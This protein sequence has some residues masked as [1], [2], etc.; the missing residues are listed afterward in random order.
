MLTIPSRLIVLLTLLCAWA[1]LVVPSQAQEPY[2]EIDRLNPG[3]GAPPDD[4]VRNTPQ[5]TMEALLDSIASGD[6]DAASHLLNLS[7]LPIADQARQGP[8]LAQ[9]LH[10]IIDRKVV[11]DWHFLLQRPDALDSRA[12]S[13]NAVG[14]QVRRSLIIWILELEDRDV[15]IRLDRLKP[16]G[17]DA[18]WVFSAASVAKIDALYA[19]YGPTRLES[20]LPPALSNDAF[21]DLMWWEVLGLPV[22]IALAILAGVFTHGAL[23]FAARR[24]SNKL[25]TPLLHAVHTPLVIFAVTFVISILTSN[26]FVFS[27]RISTFLGPIISIG[28][29]LVALMLVINVVDAIL[30]HIVDF[31]DNALSELDN[32][33]RRSLVT[34]LA[35]GRRALI[36][37]IVLIGSGIVLTQAELFNT[38]GFSL[39]A[40]AGALT[41]ILAFAARTVLGNI[42]SS[43]QIALNQSARIGDR[44]VF[45]DAICD[46]ERINFTFVQLRTWTGIRLV[47]P[48]SEFVSE[49]FENWTLRTDG[50]TRLIVLKLRHEAKVD[51][52]RAMFL[53][54]AEHLDAGEIGNPDDLG[55]FVTGHDVF[56]Q[57]VTFCLP[58]ANPREAWEMECEMRE[59][60]MHY[61]GEL[62][63]GGTP[64]FPDVNPAEA[65]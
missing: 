48:V 20:Y 21:W 46:V 36:I 8:E 15:A 65:A 4:L 57:D 42:M 19:L 44:I 25:S 47:V 7:D 56:G 64:L 53:E 52:L 50:L 61:A 1:F 22:V 37:L 54:T 45:R 58:C 30:D 16:E 32:T 34:R 6:F 40:S 60:L 63:A 35:A 23:S 14:G 33:E 59:R 28:F 51:K 9:K 5:A 2:F 38:L 18:V 10:T 43:M 13:D 29:V 27:G 11:I 62:E 55:V 31:R 12:S 26:L 17:A 49:P 3:L 41:L 24:A 39:L